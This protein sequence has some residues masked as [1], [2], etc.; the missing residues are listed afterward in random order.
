MKVGVFL[1]RKRLPEELQ[2]TTIY[3]NVP[4]W[5]IRILEK[6]GKPNKVILSIIEKYVLSKKIDKC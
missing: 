4:N 1:G 3:L 6:E 2:K 5:I